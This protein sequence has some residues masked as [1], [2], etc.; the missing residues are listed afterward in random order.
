MK[1]NILLDTDECVYQR[2][3]LLGLEVLNLSLAPLS[4]VGL[5]LSA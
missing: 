1:T 2:K 4:E 3:F 5:K